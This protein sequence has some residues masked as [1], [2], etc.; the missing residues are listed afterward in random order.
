MRFL[1]FKSHFRRF[2]VFSTADIRKWDRN[3]DTRR[4]VEWQQKNYIR[5]IINR[6]YI[7]TDEQIDENLL[8]LIANRIYSPSYVSF[9]SALSFYHLIP[10]GVFSVASV[11]TLKTQRFDTS[12][13]TFLYRHLKPNLFFGY[14]LIELNGHFYRMAEPEKV[15]LDYLYLNTTLTTPDDIESLRVNQ[16]ELQSLL[17]LERLNEYLSL[18]ENKALEKRVGIFLNV[19]GYAQV[20]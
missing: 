7:F 10:E 2:R 4:L 20:G 15:I 19:M 11:T 8:Y 13:G 1:D 3:F 12:L 17:D 9:E 16:M 14:R 5:R 18:F 6:W